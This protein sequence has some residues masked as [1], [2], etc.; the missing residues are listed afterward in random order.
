MPQR[1]Y[2]ANL[3]SLAHMTESKITDILLEL[4]AKIRREEGSPLPNTTLYQQLVDSLLYL[5]MIH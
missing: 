4:K 5:T 3:L 1:K 2:A